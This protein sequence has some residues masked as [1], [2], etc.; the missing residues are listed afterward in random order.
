MAV[1][2]ITLGNQPASFMRTITFTNRDGSESKLPVTFKYRDRVAYTAWVE[3]TAKK[4]L[5]AP[6]VEGLAAEAGQRIEQEA[7]ELT[8]MLEGWVLDGHDFTPE[9]CKL[10]CRELPQAVSAIFITYRDACLY[11]KSG[12]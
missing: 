1:V 8:E 9:N 6:K 12:N 4:R 10:L 11:G 7:G 2:P 3:E 5:D